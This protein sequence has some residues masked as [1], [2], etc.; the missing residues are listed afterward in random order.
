MRVASDAQAD[1]GAGASAPAPKVSIIGLSKRYGGVQALADVGFDAMPG[2]IHAVVGENG[3]G[4]STLMKIMAG[5]VQPDTGTILLDGEPFEATTPH[6]AHERGVGIVYQE[7]SL[8]PDRSVLANLFPDREA[9][10]FGLISLSTMERAARPM[11]REIGLDVPLSR[12]VGFLP[13]GEQQL[14]ELCR[15]LLSAP[16]VLILDEPNSALSEHETE[17]LFAVLRKMRDSGITI[18]Y[19]SHRLE[20]V[21]AIADT[22]T[23]MRNGRH[24]FTRPRAGLTIPD[25]VRAMLGR[26]ERALYP[27]RTGAGRA[28]DASARRI[29]VSKLAVRP[30]LKDVSF[31]AHAGEIVGLAGIQGSGVSDLLGALFGVRKAIR[32]TVAYPDGHGLPASATQSARRGVSLVPS[33]RRNQGL[34]LE[35]S[36]AQ[37]VSQVRG[38][39]LGGFKVWLGRGELAR[40]AQRQIDALRIKAPSPWTQVHHLSGGNQQKVVIGKWLEISPGVILLDDPA[41]GVD[42]GAKQEIFALVRALADEGK[43]VLFHSTEVPELIGLSDRIVG[44]HRGRVVLDLPATSLDSSTLLHAINTGESPVTNGGTR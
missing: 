26:E 15:V 42:V 12:P 16:S 43:I 25:V 33:D 39:A 28:G 40:A 22:V 5:A 35:H 6:A 17:R 32:G 4:K 19:V 20:E 21:F 18:F 8:F 37:N 3:A 7:L 29:T 27:E 38:G 34:M 9:T 2:S 31:E 24:V 13:I 23:V 44:L 10:R 36:I 1:Q 11:L 41:R 30:S 14:V